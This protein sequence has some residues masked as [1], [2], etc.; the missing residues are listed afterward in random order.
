MRFEIFICFIVALTSCSSNNTA[1]TDKDVD[2][3]I[4]KYNEAQFD[5][6]KNISIAQRSR[7]V[8]EIVY[9]VGKSEGSLPVYFVTYDLQK[10]SITAINKNNLEKSKVQDYFTRDE[11]SNAVNAI[12]KFGFYFLSVDSSENVYVNPFYVNEP[13][14]LLRLKA[15]TEDST[16]RK[17]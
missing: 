5:A 16:V 13:A 9:V 1:I 6:V 7:N 12:R 17:G 14:Y 4:S 2:E 15:L 11:I 8:D 3:F 10:K